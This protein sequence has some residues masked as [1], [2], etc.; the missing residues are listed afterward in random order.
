M[1]EEISFGKKKFIIVRKKIHHI[2]VFSGVDTAERV[3]RMHDLKI[4][5]IQIINTSFNR[6]NMYA[7]E[8]FI[9]LFLKRPELS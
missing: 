2:Y 3:R 6:F 9:F 4:S 1:G 8:Y 7:R 5:H